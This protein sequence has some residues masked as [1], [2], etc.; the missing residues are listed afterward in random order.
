M[1]FKKTYVLKRGTW[2]GT[3]YESNFTQDAGSFASI[4]EFLSYVD[5]PLL[6]FGNAAYSTGDVIRNEKMLST[7][8]KL[9][10]STKEYVDEATHDAYVNNVVFA[11][12]E[13]ATKSYT[14]ELTEVS[15]EVGTFDEENR[16]YY[17]DFEHLF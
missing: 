4:S 1:A 10:F 12:E 9:M 6:D 15:E 7:D 11:T 3:P 8:G 14:V 13:A 17:S 16:I 2:D 5:Q